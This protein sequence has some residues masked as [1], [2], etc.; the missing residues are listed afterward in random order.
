MANENMAYL[1]NGILFS[2]KKNKILSFVA[3]WMELEVI[4]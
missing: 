4:V 2:R 3:A 1:Y